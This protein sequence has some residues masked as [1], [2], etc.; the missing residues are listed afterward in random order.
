MLVAAVV[1]LALAG[2]GLAA[3]QLLGSSSA[4]ATPPPKTA[5]TIATHKKKTSK[6]VSPALIA[7]HYLVGASQ[8][9]AIRLL[10]ARG[11]RAR[12]VHE[13]ST[14]TK[15]HVMSQVPRRGKRREKNAVVRLVVST[16]PVAKRH[17]SAP[18][19]PSDRIRLPRLS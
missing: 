18:P 14:V 1:L 9:R 5:S 4:V 12:V 6:P 2:A 11:L 8:A 16:G 10:R 13:H 3:T 15:G 7:V 17:V 19:R